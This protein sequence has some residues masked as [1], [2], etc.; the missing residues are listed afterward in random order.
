MPAYPSLFA[1]ATL[2]L[3]LAAVSQAAHAQQ[4]GPAATSAMEERGSD[5]QG[6][7]AY[8]ADVAPYIE[9]SQVISA[10][11]QPGD[12]V[13]TYTQLA[14]GVDATIA[15]RNSAAS[16][17][18]RYERDIGYGDALDSD[19]VSGIARAS[20]SLYRQGITLEAGGLASRTSVDGSGF[21]SVGQI[22][23]NEGSTSHIYSV[24]AGPA[25]QTRSGPA[26][27]SGQYRLGYTRVE[28][29]DALALAPG[30]E[31]VDIFDDS[32]TH[33]AA[34]R[35]GVA[36][37][38]VAPVGVGVGGGWNRQ[39]ISNLDQRIDDKYVRGDV[40]LPVSLT[41]ALVAGVG[42]EYVEVSSRDALIDAGGNVVVGPD[43]RL[44]TDDSQPR[45]IAY[46]T[47]GLIW[48]VGVMWRPS[49]RTS[50]SAT[51]GRRYGSTTYYGTLSYAASRNSGLSIAVY[52]NIT[53]FG[54][55][56]TGALDL[57][58]TEFTAVRNPISGDLG[59]CVIG[60]EGNN[61]TLA[62]LNSLRSAVFRNRGVSASYSAVAGRTS[63][64]VGA[65][66]DRRSFIG[67]E[68]TVL[69]AVDGVVD[70]SYYIAANIAHQLDRNSGLSAGAYASWF[71]AGAGDLGDGIGYSASLAYNRDIWRGLT[72]IAAV[73]IDGISRDDD[74]TDY[75]SASALLGLRYTFD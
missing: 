21:S 43:G 41:V 46:Q 30:E 33:N 32:V 23:G 74:L 56:L 49:R 45:R 50:L 9:A 42:Y 1:R 64:G 40:T 62:Q 39:D 15:G 55:Q 47:D 72:G 29:P 6:E 18:L 71:D 69:A 4:E 8:G 48:D 61:C 58:G 31:S 65:G 70:E 44:V 12:D 3:A 73:G 25:I 54:G 26:E 14:A 22:A 53:G 27:I 20:L 75:S 13:L 7:R 24:Y 66:Y 10:Q 28:S 5:E 37:Y 35:V 52:D 16:A 68:D 19:T 60:V 51:V 38:T 57:L 59:G 34:L 67:A 17:S 2:A 63:F 11:L 36:P